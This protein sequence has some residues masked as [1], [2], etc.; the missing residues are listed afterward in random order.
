[1]PRYMLLLSEGPCQFASTAPAEMQAMLERYMAWSR[2]LGQ[3]GK[4]KGG[5]KLADEPGKRLK[6]DGGRIAVDG[7]FTETR[8]MVSGLFMVEAPDY[9]A[10]VEIAMTCP[11]MDCGTIVVHQID[12]MKG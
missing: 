1:M 8:E 5:E 2:K 12:D 10:A 7:P 3:E 9:G 11:H 6:R 4:L